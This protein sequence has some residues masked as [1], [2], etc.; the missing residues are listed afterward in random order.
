MTMIANMGKSHSHQIRKRKIRKPPPSKTLKQK[1]I[2]IVETDGDSAWLKVGK[3]RYEINRDK[4][5][6]LVKS[7]QVI[8][9]RV[10]S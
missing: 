8:I 6:A 1:L 4:F 9:V 3:K 5:D 2:S 10:K 7:G